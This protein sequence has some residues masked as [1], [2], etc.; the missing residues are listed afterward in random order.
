MSYWFVRSPAAS[1]AANGPELAY[2]TFAYSADWHQ[3]TR[4]Q[5][6]EMSQ[7]IDSS[8]TTYHGGQALP[9]LPAHSPACRSCAFA[10]RCGR[11]TSVAESAVAALPW[12]LTESLDRLWDAIEEIPI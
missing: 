11:S 8:I 10:S 1:T 7:A 5:L 6:L 2:E 3:A 12:T 4:A 9:Q